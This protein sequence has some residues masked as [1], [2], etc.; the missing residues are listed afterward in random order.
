MDNILYA[1]HLLLGKT[2]SW[3]TVNEFYHNHAERQNGKFSDKNLE[4]SGGEYFQFKRN[5]NVTN[6]KYHLN[7]CGS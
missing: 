1:V 2:V 7:C 3:K 5:I 6:L 4:P